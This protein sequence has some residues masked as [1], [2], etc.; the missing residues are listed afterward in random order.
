MLSGGAVRDGEAR[1]GIKG[2]GRL[3]LQASS[4]YSSDSSAA[5]S[6]AAAARSI[7]R[8]TQAATSKH[9]ESSVRLFRCVCCFCLFCASYLDLVCPDGVVFVPLV[10]VFDAARLVVPLERLPHQTGAKAE[11]DAESKLASNTLLVLNNSGKRTHTKRQQ[12]AAAE[13]QSEEQ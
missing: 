7:C 8:H 9:G 2:D 6:P 12:T 3:K 1:G 10:V 11:A 4:A 5:V 13:Q